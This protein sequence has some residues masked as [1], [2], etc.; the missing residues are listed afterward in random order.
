MR[1]GGC[2]APEQYV[3]KDLSRYLIEMHPATNYLK[4]F[5]K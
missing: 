3:V 1:G 5:P 2:L 4:D